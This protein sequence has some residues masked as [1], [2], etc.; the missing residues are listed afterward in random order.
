MTRRLAIAIV[1]GA[2][3]KIGAARAADPFT[4]GLSTG[5][6]GAYILRGFKL[7]DSGESSTL[8]AAYKISS[9]LSVAGSVWN[10]EA[11]RQKQGNATDIDGH[12]AWSPKGVPVAFGLG[13]LYYGGSIGGD[14]KEVYAN[15]AA[16]KLSFNPLLAVYHGYA[17][18]THTVVWLQASHGWNLGKDWS[19]ALWGGVGANWGK[20]YAPDGFAVAAVGNT[21]THPLNKVLSL[22]ATLD[23]YAAN[24]KYDRSLR[25]VPGVNLAYGSAF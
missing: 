16:T 14:I 2:T 5:Y 21:F 18:P 17:H 1:L 6:T 10:Y 19:Y 15:V 24:R 7:G 11:Y 22:N 25:L 20:A 3:V 23:F 13:Y 9:T 12:L 8:S 4:V